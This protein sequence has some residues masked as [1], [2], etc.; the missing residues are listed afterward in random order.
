[1]GH[2]PLN[3][4]SGAGVGTLPANQ[5]DAILYNVPLA[6]E[7]K[8]SIINTHKLIKSAKAIILFQDSGGF[9]LHEELAAGKTV[10]FDVD[11]EVRENGILNLTPEHLIK[12]A[13]E[14]KPDA[15]VSLDNPI[16]K[17]TNPTAAMQDINFLEHHGFNL[18]WA[19]ETSRL[20]S[21]HCPE[22]KLFVPVQCYRLSHLDQFLEDFGDTP[23]DGFSIPVRNH[24][25]FAIAVF[26]FKLYHSGCR[27]IH[28]LGTFT[29]RTISL[30]SYFARHY[31]D[32]VSLDCTLWRSD[33]DLSK[34]YWPLDLRSLQL[35][36]HY[37][38]DESVKNECQCPWCKGKTFTMIKNLPFA[39]Q[40]GLL[41]RHNYWTIGQCMIEF[42]NHAD[43]ALSLKTFLSEHSGRKKEIK[44]IYNYLNM[45]EQLKD[46]K[47][48]T[49]IELLNKAFC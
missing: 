2:P 29:F 37:S 4:C 33:A 35:K 32:F 31:F 46:E 18:R 14:F 5:H 13:K 6:M 12:A 16:P 8:T 22:I 21:K 11:K 34:Y 43:T 40:S 36:N 19:K 30:A 39:E 23:C 41:R 44:Q 42:Y 49:A 1:M 20:R 15:M 3:V 47:P 48:E 10:T 7:S 27:K 28:I 17:I 25:P 45:L 9:Q 38:I 26:M 24:S